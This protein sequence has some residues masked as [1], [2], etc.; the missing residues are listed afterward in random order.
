M[1]L[2]SYQSSDCASLAEL[3]YHTVHL[4]NAADYTSEQLDVWASGT[5]DLEAWDAS[6]ILHDTVIAQEQEKIIGFGDM[7]DHGYLDRLYVHHQYQRRGVA[8]AIV[9][10]LEERA[11][12]KGV[13][14]FTTYA[15]ITAL[16]FFEKKGYRIFRENQVERNGIMLK[17]YLMKKSIR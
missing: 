6:F 11:Q 9:A 2:R 8:S 3:F 1:K 5:V 16:P 12:Q 14:Q 4:V 17:N 7:A 15:S 13:M 10:Y